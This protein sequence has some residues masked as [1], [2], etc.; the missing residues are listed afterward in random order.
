[1]R[2]CAYILSHNINVC[3]YF[4]L[5]RYSINKSTGDAKPYNIYVHKIIKSTILFGY[6]EC[7]IKAFYRYIQESFVYAKHNIIS[8]SHFPRNTHT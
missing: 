5:R 3:V 7:I 2:I 8:S 4:M 1:M 6:S